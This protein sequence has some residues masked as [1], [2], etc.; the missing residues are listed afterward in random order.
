MNLSSIAHN[1]QYFAD[2]EYS[3]AIKKIAELER[4][5]KEKEERLKIIEGELRLHNKL[6][7]ISKVDK[8]N[9][10]NKYD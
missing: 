8:I 7:R 10:I 6:S 2:H 4:L 9:L 1:R 5:L 3:I